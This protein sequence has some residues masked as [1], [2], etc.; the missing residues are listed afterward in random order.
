MSSY[1]CPVDSPA[2]HGHLSHLPC[3]QRLPSL[4]T[5]L[6]FPSCRYAACLDRTEFGIYTHDSMRHAQTNNTLHH[7]PY[8]PIGSPRKERAAEPSAPLQP[9]S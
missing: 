3:N 9:T 1:W 4:L 5:A 2:A 8:R 7:Q 6:R